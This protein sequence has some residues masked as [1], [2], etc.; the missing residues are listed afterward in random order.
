MKLQSD[1]TVAYALNKKGDNLNKLDLKSKDYYL[2]YYSASWCPPCRKFTPKLV[3]YYNKH[4]KS[5]N[6]ELIFVS[7]DRS[8]DAT[9]KY[10][11]DYKM[12]W[13]AVK[14]SRMK[15][16][17]LKKY[18]GRGI[19]SLVLFD[20]K[21]EVLAKSYDNGNYLGPSVALSKLDELRK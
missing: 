9:E 5:D 4:A 1:V 11:Q 12:P 2:V 14:L 13:P 19:P 20:K 17:D 18:G 15:Y 21:G 16:V 10:M 7:S 8:D 3:N 6:F